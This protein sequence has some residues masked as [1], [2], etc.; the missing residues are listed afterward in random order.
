MKKF[1]LMVALL[2]SLVGFCP[3]QQ[4]IYNASAGTMTLTISVDT[5][6]QMYGCTGYHGGPP[7][8]YYWHTGKVSSTLINKRTNQTSTFTKTVTGGVATATAVVNV[9][10]GDVVSF[11]ESNQVYCP[12]TGIW[13]GNPGSMG[14]YEIAYTRAIFTGTVN[15]CSEG[16]TGT[17]CN[18]SVTDHC[19]IDTTPPDATYVNGYIRDQAN[20]YWTYWDTVNICYRPSSPAHAP[21]SCYGLGVEGYQT[22]GVI[23]PKSC[24]HNP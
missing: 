15:N 23:A 18:F 14:D 3:A 4:P 8:Q 22:G 24:T 21:W 17:I 11:Q 10:P 9:L 13:S 16:V 12:V 19:T 5:S 6:A 2:C 7:C 20:A 1:F